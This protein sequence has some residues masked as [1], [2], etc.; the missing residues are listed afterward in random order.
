ME[1]VEIPTLV[2]DREFLPVY[3]S[4]LAAGADVKACIGQGFREMKLSHTFDHPILTAS[5]TNAEQRK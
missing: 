2:S 5:T 4:P 3:A 1:E